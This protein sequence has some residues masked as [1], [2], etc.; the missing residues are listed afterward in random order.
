MDACI[1]NKQCHV[2]K[3][4]DLLFAYKANHSTVQ[5][6]STIKEIISYYNLNRSPVYMCM[7]DASKAFDKVNLLLL[8][9]KLRLKGM[10]PLLLRF[11]INMYIGQNI[12]VKWNDCISHVYAVSNGVKQGGVMSPLLF[13]L[14]VQDLIECLDRKGLG[15]HMGKPFFWM[16]YLCR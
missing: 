13:N 9:N 3:F 6:V 16:F 10:C 5:C 15:C 4:H 11:I 8:F 14:Y 2:F 7:L 12:R 1:I